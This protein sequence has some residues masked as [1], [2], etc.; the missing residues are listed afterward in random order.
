M[1]FRHKPNSLKTNLLLTAFTKPS[2]DR[3][4]LIRMDK[5]TKKVVICWERARALQLNHDYDC[6]YDPSD[7]WC[8]AKTQC[9][10]EFQLTAHRL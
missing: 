2:A 9:G 5:A 8:E 1:N 10:A 4:V 6:R 7:F 3:G